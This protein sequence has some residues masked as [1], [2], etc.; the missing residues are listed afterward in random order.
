MERKP[1]RECLELILNAETKD[2]K[3]RKELDNLGIK[4]YTLSMV[5]SKK[6]VDKAREGDLKAYSI[7]Q[8]SIHEAPSETETLD[9]T[10]NFNKW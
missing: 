10:L 4:D 9:D 5:I 6:L 1:L 8:S 3:E 2:D 7:I